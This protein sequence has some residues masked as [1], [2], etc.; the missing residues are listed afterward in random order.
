MSAR[1]TRGGPG[2]L[3]LGALALATACAPGS[4][5]V[6]AAGQLGLGGRRATRSFLELVPDAPFVTAFRGERLVE[7]FYEVDG[8]PRTL[9]YREDVGSN[10]EGMFAVEGIEALE[11][12]DNPAL[13]RLMHTNRANFM[14]RYRD[15]RI[16]DLD[17]FL[18]NFDARIVDES[19]D[20]AGVQCSALHIERRSGATTHFEV[21]I[22]PATGLVMSWEE[23]AQDGALLSRVYFETFELGGDLAG[24]DLVTNRYSPQP[25]D[26]NDPDEELGFNLWRPTLPPTGYELDSAASFVDETGRTWAKLV[27]GN[28]A[29]H[30]FFLQGEPLVAD[31]VPVGQNTSDFLERV[32][33][34]PWTMIHGTIDDVPVILMGKVAGGQLKDM[35]QSALNARF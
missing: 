5:A 28:G 25:L 3:V 22:D 14:Y 26:E 11:G 9:R 31:P 21:C 35:L 7:F 24:L 10:G 16:R 15:F 34:G 4:Q 30:V 6:Q 23:R 29:D 27:Y 1:G 2:V 33:V 13:F 32:V 18:R 19:R 12:T 8:E 20:V 17:R